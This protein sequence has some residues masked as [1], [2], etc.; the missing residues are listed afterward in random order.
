MSNSSHNYFNLLDSDS[1]HIILAYCDHNEYYDLS[2]VSQYKNIDHHFLFR[3][4]YFKYLRKN[5]KEFDVEMI[6]KAFMLKDDQDMLYTHGSDIFYEDYNFSDLHTKKYILSNN[7]FGTYDLIYSVCVLD[8]IDVFNLYYQDE[9]SDNLSDTWI[10]DIIVNKSI[11][12][13]KYI[14]K[15]FTLDFNLL[16]D[17][18]M[19]V[20]NARDSFTHTMEEIFRL[21]INYD[22]RF[23]IHL[24]EITYKKGEFELL[25]FIFSFNI[26]LES[27]PF[28]L[29]DYIPDEEIYPKIRLMIDNHYALIKDQLIKV[30][31]SICNNNIWSVDLSTKP[32]FLMYLSN[33]IRDEYDSD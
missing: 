2:E 16:K 14:L 7:L 31:E 5:I 25:R 17:K 13:M 27:I 28:S 23:Y 24:F 29:S 1:F 4:K 19:E 12:L 30:Y 20:L 15:T 6:Y 3:L 21:L 9:M 33:L 32:K 10:R 22:N 26:K 18:I 8:D 11:H